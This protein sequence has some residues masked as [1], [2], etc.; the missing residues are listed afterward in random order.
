MPPPASATL[1]IANGSV[2]TLESEARVP[3]LYGIA[4]RLLDVYVSTL[5]LLLLSPI[6]VAVAIAIR[7]DS[8]GPILFLQER[9]G[10]RGRIFRVVKFRS[11]RTDNDDSVH[12]AYVTSLINGVAD[13]Q[14]GDNGDVFKLL[15]DDRITRVGK[16]IRRTSLDELPQLLNVLS[17]SMSLVGPRPPLAYEVA[18]YDR[19]HMRR[20]AVKPGITGLWQVSGRNALGFEEMVALDVHYVETRSFRKDL[21]I[22]LCTVPAV[23]GRTGG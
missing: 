1:E 11:M 7:V 14:S 23:F 17:G 21:S 9:V 15:N 5:M 8:A 18:L 4:K 13:T 6:L 22:L 2:L 16:F 12:R 20:L 10:R 19:H 3:R